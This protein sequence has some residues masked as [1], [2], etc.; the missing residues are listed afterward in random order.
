MFVRL[1]SLGLLFAGVISCSSR[2]YTNPPSAVRLDTSISSQEQHLMDSILQFGLDHEALFTLLGDVKPMSSLI[3]FYYP[4][5]NTDSTLKTGAHVISRDTVGYYLDKL[6]KV[7][8]AMNKLNLP[9]LRFIMLPYQYAQGNRRVIQLSV[10]RISKLDSLLQAKESFFGQ[11]GLVPG[12][13]P[14]VVA[15]V[16]ENADRY[17]RNRGYG[18]LFGYPDYAVDFFVEAAYSSIEKDVFIARKFFQIPAFA[19][20]Q[21]FFVYA[22]P[23]DHQPT[24]AVDSVLYHKSAV[25]LENYKQIRKQYLNADS[26]IRAHQLLLDYYGT[27]KDPAALPDEK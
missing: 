1:I 9:D 11:F 2:R 21:G 23:E 18:Y 15:S 14:V 4:L 7:Q 20:K 19:G 22:Y 8:R 25:I 13:D 12:T 6:Q 3:I 27:V 16:I 26:T 10:V 24:A 5:A 17:E